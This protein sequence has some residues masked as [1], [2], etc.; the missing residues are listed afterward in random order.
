MHD[1]IEPAGL[2]APSARFCH[3]YPGGVTIGLLHPGE[4]G[5]QVGRCLQD[6]GH[7]VL[8]A[9]AGRGSQTRARAAAAGLTDAGTT[10]ALAE[11]ADLILSV[12]P[13]HAAVEVARSVAGFGGLYLDANAIAPQTAREVASIISA[14]GGQYVDGGI[15][16]PPPVSRESTR[17]Y[18]SGAAA[19]QVQRL[20][21]G[22]ALEARIAG[23]GPFAASAVKMAY[24]GWTKGSAALLL[25]VRALAEAEGVADVLAAEWA[26]SQPG[27]EDRLAGAGRSAA[28]KGWRWTAE[29][30][31]VAET[32]S[33]A[34]LPGGFWLAAA[35]VFGRYP[36]PS[37]EPDPPPKSR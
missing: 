9:S 8:W 21:D 22:S 19:P 5:A 3:R 11:Q 6:A 18:L 30:E 2:L 13:P 16:G 33:S 36:R 15:I 20:F 24:A 28:G 35:E 27:L 23:T 1:S 4:M 34:G 17:L 32:V 29:M 12:C 10:G 25:T 7:R 26:L 31:Q 14:R 37:A